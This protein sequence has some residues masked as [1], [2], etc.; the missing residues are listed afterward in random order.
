MESWEL[1][2]EQ[3]LQTSQVRGHDTKDCRPVKNKLENM[4]KSRE[5]PLLE[6]T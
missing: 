3:V 6:A 5:L 4:F 2:T 1:G